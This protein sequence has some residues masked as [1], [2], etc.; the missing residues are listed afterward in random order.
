MLF[1]SIENIE[2]SKT[3]AYSAQTN[4]IYERFY[5]TM[6][7]EFY[8]TAFRK[9]IYKSVEESQNDVAQWLKYY[10]EERPHSDKYTTITYLP[11]K[12]YLT[13]RHVKNKCTSD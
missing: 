1:L 10:N 7:Q 4:G 5:K 13:A 8:D 3:K 2:H 9:K 12:N 11:S 6:K